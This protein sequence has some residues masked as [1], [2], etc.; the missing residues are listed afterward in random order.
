MPPCELKR[1]LESNS[2]NFPRSSKAIQPFHVC[3]LLTK[4]E[5]P[6][7]KQLLYLRWKTRVIG[8]RIDEIHHS[9][10]KS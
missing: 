10:R 9:P 2:G 3:L 4:S 6:E 8:F 7:A 1:Q 5:D